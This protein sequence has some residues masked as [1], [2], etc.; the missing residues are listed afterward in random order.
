M[1]W[2]E[3]LEMVDG[4]EIVEGSELLDSSCRW[5]VVVFTRILTDELHPSTGVASLLKTGGHFW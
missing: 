2:S 5:I 3:A 1:S 4:S